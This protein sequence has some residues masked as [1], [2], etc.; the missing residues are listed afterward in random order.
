MEVEKNATLGSYSPIFLVKK[1]ENGGFQDIIR[2]TPTSCKTIP[3]II[4]I[5]SG[6]VLAVHYHVH[7]SHAQIPR[8]QGTGIRQCCDQLQ[9]SN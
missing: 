9:K 1:K 6:A 2:C 5:S 4:K 8:L 7:T 3:Q